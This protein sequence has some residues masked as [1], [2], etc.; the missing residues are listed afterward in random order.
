MNSALEASGT[1]NIFFLALS[2]LLD[3]IAPIY[4]MFLL[5]MQSN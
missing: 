1:K 5:Q 3:G 4:A 2:G